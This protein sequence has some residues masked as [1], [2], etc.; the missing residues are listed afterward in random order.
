MGFFL[1]VLIF[2]FAILTSLSEP[3]VLGQIVLEVLINANYSCVNLPACDKHVAAV[4]KPAALGCVPKLS[5]GVLPLFICP[6]APL[7]LCGGTERRPGHKD[8]L[9]RCAATRISSQQGGHC[10]PGL[11]E[12]EG[13]IA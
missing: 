3:R 4:I 7:R 1:L 13:V 6:K 11:S 10:H 12:S 2:P 8:P 9:M 5:R